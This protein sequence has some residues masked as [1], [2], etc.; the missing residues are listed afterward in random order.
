[1]SSSKPLAII[2]ISMLLFALLLVAGSSWM[3]ITG[4][5]DGGANIGGGILYMF[6]L[7]VG[8]ASFILGIISLFVVGKNKSRRA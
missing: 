7:I 2:A 5:T 3:L 1:M 6:G 8:A 4:P